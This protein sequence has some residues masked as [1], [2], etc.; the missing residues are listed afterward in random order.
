MANNRSQNYTKIFRYSPYF[1]EKVRGVRLGQERLDFL[2]LNILPICN[3][4]CDKCFASIGGRLKSTKNQLSLN[5]I[6]EI[7]N[8]AA[9]LG[10]HYIEISGRG[11]PLIFW[12]QIQKIISYARNLGIGT[13]IFTNGFLLN[14]EIL[15]FMI[16]NSTSLMVSFDWLE[17]RLYEK[18]VRVS[19]VFE[20]VIRNI[21]LAR[22]TF[23]D[24]IEF[25]NGYQVM[26][27]G[28]HTIVSSGNFSQVPGIKAFIRDDIF[29][30]VAPIAS[31]LG[32]A[33]SHI[34]LRISNQ[35]EIRNVIQRY[36]DNSVILCGSS[37]GSLGLN[38][39]GTLYYGLGIDY[40][41]EVLIDAHAFET[42]GVIGN[43]RNIS[44]LDAIETKKD[45]VNLFYERFGCSFCPL[46][47]PNYSLFVNFI[48]T[49]EVL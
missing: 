1:I 31:E 29:Y 41:G 27:F 10:I 11:E 38:V 47:D 16:E 42:A 30:S 14:E 36:S 46:R 12:P 15:R 25:I 13:L 20:K 22:E 5:E 23:R 17:Q 3:Y 7:I 39:C 21:E 2:S 26:S 40:D 8:S 48:K 18:N 4:R 6:E 45:F 33:K 24:S 44:L 19:G 37:R 28:L 9:S 43:I 49:K 32:N 34:D 35:Q